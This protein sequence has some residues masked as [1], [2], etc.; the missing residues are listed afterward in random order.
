MIEL[1]EVL[2]LARSGHITAH[3]EH[4][5]LERVADAYERKRTAPS[6][7]RRHHAARLTN[8]AQSRNRRF[9]GPMPT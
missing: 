8:H 1:A 6:G 2:E 5:P 4:F 3:A 9:L 7:A